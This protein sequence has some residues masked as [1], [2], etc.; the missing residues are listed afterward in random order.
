MIIEVADFRVA[1]E[2]RDEF[3][4]AMV[5]AM[6]SMLGK[7]KGYLGHQILSC[8]ESPERVLLI[9]RWQTLEDHTVGFRQSPAFAEW[10]AIIGPF[11]TQPPQVE[12]FSVADAS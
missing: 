6:K 11:F 10:R 3:Q 7:S 1:A 9:V 4:A 5:G 2:R 12:H 8:L